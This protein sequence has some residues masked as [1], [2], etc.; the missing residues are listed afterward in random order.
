MSTEPL[1][2]FALITATISVSIALTILI[3]SEVKM[4]KKYNLLL[5]ENERLRLQEHKKEL[6]ILEAARQKAAKII[7]EAHFVADNTKQEFQEQLRIVSLN[8]TKDFENI[9]SDFLKLYKQDL[10]DLKLN[11]IKIVNNITKDIENNTVMELKDFKEILKKETYA[12][13]KIVE[14]KIEEVYAETNKE[15]ETYKEDRIKKVEDEIYN[16]IQNVAS[17]VLGKAISLKDHE[18]LVVDALNKAKEKS[19]L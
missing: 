17:L 12:S 9:A 3:A 5:K 13:Q 15:I 19:V 2:F 7:A 14:G 4:L 11:T 8:K 16:I 6:E 10:E 18:Q 1:I